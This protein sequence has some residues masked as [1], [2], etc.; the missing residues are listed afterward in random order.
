MDK[1]GGFLACAL[2]RGTK[3][4]KIGIF[5]FLAILGCSSNEFRHRS[6]KQEM[7]WK[8]EKICVLA[9][10]KLDSTVLDKLAADLERTFE[11]K[12]EITRI[13]LD[14]EFAYNPERKQYH[15][16][17]VLERLRQMGPE[18]CGRTLGIVDVDLY[19]PDLNFVFGEANVVTKTAVIAK[20]RLKPEYYGLAED[21]TLLGERILKESVHEL[22]HTYGLGHCS[23]RKCVM[24]FSNSLAD[25]DFKSSSFCKNCKGNLVA[26][27]KLRSQEPEGRS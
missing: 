6:E 23:D 25:T 8:Q 22:G 24:R 26:I 10:G 17:T 7:A 13:P 14:L 11:R 4:L 2:S 16:S 21:P 12:V 27:K 5:T 20:E 3:P 18:D 19:V 1:R 15:S 9:I